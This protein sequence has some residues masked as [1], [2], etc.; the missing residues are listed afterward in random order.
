MYSLT[1]YGLASIGMW[2]GANGMYS[3]LHSSQWAVEGTG[4]WQY[5][6]AAMGRPGGSPFQQPAG[7]GAPQPVRKGGVL[8]C[9]A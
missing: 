6:A 8:G 4:D 7:L 5:E 1:A 9:E 3:V 2:Q